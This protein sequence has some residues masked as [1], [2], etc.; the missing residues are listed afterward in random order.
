MI[1]VELSG[2]FHDGKS[3][4]VA[5]LDDEVL[6]PVLHRRGLDTPGLK[7]LAYRYSGRDHDG[8]PVCEIALGEE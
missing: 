6:V 8:V 5:S 1:A 7:R 3:W 2:G 4:Q